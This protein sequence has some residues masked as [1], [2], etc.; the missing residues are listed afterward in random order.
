MSSE[1]PDLV[2]SRI[3]VALDA[4][5]HSLAALEAGGTGRSATVSLL[6]W[7]ATLVAGVGLAWVLKKE[8]I[9]ALIRG[10]GR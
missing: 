4:S 9:L 6:P 3:L 7:S 5:P 2:V 8:H 1:E 10:E